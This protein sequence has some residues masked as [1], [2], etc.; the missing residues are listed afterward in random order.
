[1]MENI[2]NVMKKKTF[3]L[4]Y[5]TLWGNSSGITTVT[6]TLGTEAKTDSKIYHSITSLYF[7]ACLSFFFSVPFTVL[8]CRRD[9]WWQAQG[10]DLQICVLTGSVAPLDGE[11]RPVLKPLTY[12]FQCQWTFFLTQLFRYQCCLFEFRLACVCHLRCVA[13][14]HKKFSQSHCPNWMWME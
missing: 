5:G 4:N 14:Q 1:M 12:L 13:F 10:R 11:V 2:W 9:V 7:E 3:F 8:L 6:L